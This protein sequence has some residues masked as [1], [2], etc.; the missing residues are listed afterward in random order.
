MRS[1]SSFRAVIIGVATTF[2]ATATV[3][4]QAQIA[5]YAPTHHV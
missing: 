5:V 1:F 4:S 2:P 3:P